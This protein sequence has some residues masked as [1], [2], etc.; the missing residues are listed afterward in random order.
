MPL[1]LSLSSF[2]MPSHSLPLASLVLSL[3]CFKTCLKFYQLV[4][5]VPVLEL[6]SLSEKG[7]TPSAVG[8]PDVKTTIPQSKG[9]FFP[10]TSD[11][12]P[13]VGLIT[14]P[15]PVVILSCYWN[16]QEK[17][18]LC[19]WSLNQSSKVII[20]HWTAFFLK[21]KVNY[22]ELSYLQIASLLPNKVSFQLIPLR[23]TKI[24]FVSS[25]ILLA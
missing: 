17:H 19:S 24:S 6:I 4:L 21:K 20:Q 13:C 7:A 9:S 11:S 16:D 23:L 3:T 22:F 5:L 14:L 8:R 18:N 15:I 1:A 25:S 12:Y 10:V 2:G